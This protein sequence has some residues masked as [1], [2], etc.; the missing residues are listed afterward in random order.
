MD[1]NGTQPSDRLRKITDELAEELRHAQDRVEQAR[2]AYELERQQAQHVQAALKALDPGHELVQSQKKAAKSK[3]VRIHPDKLEQLWDWIVN[4]R[5][6]DHHEPFS[7]SEASGAL[8]LSSDMC[9]RGI[10]LLRDGDALR[11]AGK[12]EGESG[13]QANIFKLMDVEAGNEIV[14]ENR[15][16]FPPHVAQRLKVSNG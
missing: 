12:S 15:N 8:S 9:R 7:I 10:Q 11:L 16:Q 2:G 1:T 5:A 6:P 13:R 3:I 4:G 14:K